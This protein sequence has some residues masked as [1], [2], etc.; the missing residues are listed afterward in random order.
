M[1]IPTKDRWPLLSR[2]LDSV[3]AQED[4]AIEVVVVDDGSTDG[5][6]R[7][8]AE[9]R[10][11]RLRLVR[12]ERSRG[13][14]SA[15]N[16]GLAHAGAGWVAFLDDDDIWA[17]R[18]LR[19]ELDRAADGASFIYTGM[20]VI[21]D[22]AGPTQIHPLPPDE[23]RRN[24]LHD[25]G[26]GAPSTVMVR[27][28]LVRRVGGFDERLSALADWDLWIRLILDE[29]ATVSACP[30]P[31]V[32][33]VLHAHNMH[34]AEADSILAEFR[35]LAAKNRGRGGS[36][37]GPTF[38]HWVASSQRRSGRRLA[39]ARTYLEAAARY[40]SVGDFARGV[41]VLLGEPAMA[42]GRRPR[43]PVLTQVPPWVGRHTSE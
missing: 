22:E 32:A 8:L 11:S 13:V 20:V 41:G 29:R 3:L 18:K 38:F 39:A 5:T 40:R 9:L 34:R 10:D 30:E 4:V 25:N 7:R 12:N 15:R 17:P 36:F 33:Y 42:L 14:A 31:L 19:A 35:R 1:V 43:P 37:G 23:L 27:T 26:V 2:A 16:L 24:L 6:S 28:D 21:G